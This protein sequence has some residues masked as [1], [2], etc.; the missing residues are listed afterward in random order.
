MDL[1][2]KGKTALVA[3]ASKGLGRAIAEEFAREG[4]KV[5]MCSRDEAAISAAARDIERKTSN[6]DLLP[7]AADLSTLEGCESF[8]KNSIGA[9]R[10]IDILIVNAGGPPPG[11]FDD[12]DDKTWQKAV[13][14]TL[15]SAVRLTRLVLPQMRTQGGGSIVYSTSTSVRQPTQ[16]LNLILSNAIR[17]AVQGMMKTLSSDLAKDKIRVNAVQPGRI[18]T[19]RLIELDTDTARR[20]N[21]TPDEIRKRYESAVIPMGRYG[22]PAEYAAAVVFIAS[23][24]ASYITGTS[25][26]VDGGMLMSMF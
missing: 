5:A 19:D 26:Q 13:E 21:T 23:P 18:A 7:I 14:L 22:D 11:R 9:F 2:L 16:Y 6:K 3:A 17:A 15:F 10:A 4:T 12:L 25:L 1:G 8:V 24:K 20:Q